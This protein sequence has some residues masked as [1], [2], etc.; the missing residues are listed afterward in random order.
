MDSFF[1]KFLEVLTPLDIL[2]LYF[3]YI[4]ALPIFYIFL[5]LNA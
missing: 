1:E 4:F 3:Y 2:L 5:G